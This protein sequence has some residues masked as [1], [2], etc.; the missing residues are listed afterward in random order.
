MMYI[1]MIIFVILFLF[2]NLVYKEKK[3]MQCELLKYNILKDILLS[4]LNV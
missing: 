2:Q 1:F 3:Y 4:Y